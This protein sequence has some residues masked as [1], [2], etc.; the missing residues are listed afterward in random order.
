MGR[1]LWV[2]LVLTVTWL[3]PNAWGQEGPAGGE[4]RGFVA[5]QL[6]G[7]SIRIPG[8][9]VFLKSVATGHAGPKAVTDHRGR[10]ALPR[11]PAGQYQLCVEAPGFVA[12]CE[13]AP[14][15]IET[16]T[17]RLG[18]DVLIA[19]VPGVLRGRVLLADG[20]ACHRDQRV[21][22]PATVTRVQLVDQAGADA[23]MAGVA[24]S[25]GQ[26]VLPKIARSP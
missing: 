26:Y 22:G 25:L 10:F 14:I 18:Q 1:H 19:P 23:G 16:R 5:A 4:V 15:Y 7:T 20:N 12:R 6:R 3:A 13:T 24:N 2:A 17:V 11:H 8:V 9:T 21:C